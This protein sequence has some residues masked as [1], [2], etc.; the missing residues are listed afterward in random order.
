MTDISADEFR[1]AIAAWGLDTVQE[2]MPYRRG[3]SRSPKVR[4]RTRSGE[5]LL[6]RLAPER[7]DPARIAM[8]HAVQYELAG[9]GFPVAAPLPTLAGT[10]VLHLGPSYFELFPFIV[11]RHP[12]RSTR[13]SAESG[14]LLAHMHAILTP[15]ARTGG[16]VEPGYHRAPR[17]RRILQ[18]AVARIGSTPDRRARA[19]RTAAY[20]A[21]AYRDSARR[22]D[23]AGFDAFPVTIVHGDW[24]PGNLLATQ[25]TIVAVLDFEAVRTGP[26]VLDLAN[27]CLQ[28]AHEAATD[29]ADPATWP[30]GLSTARIRTLLASYDATAIEPLGT[31]ERA[32]I[33]WLS[34]EA[35]I[36][37]AVIPI[38]ATGRFGEIDGL[39]FLEMIE[40][41]ARW[42]RPRAARATEGH[43]P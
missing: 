37:D 28:F 30:T 15:R 36:H 18:R 2:A 31:A 13:F 11:A 25:D 7:S 14:V 40:R 12:A 19:E 21:G 41:R 24:H 6:K 26:R 39:A 42:M 4:I 34:I 9:A 29:P 10:T 32:C 38:A 16:P 22:A 23:A 3:S 33:A 27:A 17:F 20:L 43:T 35:L 8:A 1:A 5:Y